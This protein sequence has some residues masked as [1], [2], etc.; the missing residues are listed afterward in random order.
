M[1]KREKERDS[2]RENEKKREIHKEKKRKREECSI[3]DYKEEFM[4]ICKNL[5]PNLLSM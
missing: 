3:E 1:R 5:C 4:F 2:Q